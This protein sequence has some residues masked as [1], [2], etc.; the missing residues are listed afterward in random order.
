MTKGVLSQIL[1]SWL[2]LSTEK[3]DHFMIANLLFYFEYQVRSVFYFP[4]LTPPDAN[5]NATCHNPMSHIPSDH[6][7]SM[8]KTSYNHLI[9]MQIRIGAK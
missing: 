6:A 9:S 7:I 5:A 2:H 3:D 1:K 4:L 8:T